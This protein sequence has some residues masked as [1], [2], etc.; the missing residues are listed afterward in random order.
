MT[1]Q[2]HIDGDRSSP[3][4]TDTVFSHFGDVHASNAGEAFI[5]VQYRCPPGC[6]C[7]RKAV[8]PYNFSTACPGFS[9]PHLPPDARGRGDGAMRLCVGRWWSFQLTFGPGWGSWK[10]WRRS[11]SL[12]RGSLHGHRQ[13]KYRNQGLK[14]HDFVP[15]VARNAQI[16]SSY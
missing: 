3:R 11:T 14:Y 9:P 6:I 5:K 2:P 10:P 15:T 8:P 13:R 12:L 4:C 1:S 16:F 7:C